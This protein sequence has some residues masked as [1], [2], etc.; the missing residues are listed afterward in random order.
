MIYCS[1][2]FTC[3]TLAALDKHFA[4]FANTDK[5]T[6]HVRDT[7]P[8]FELPICSNSRHSSLRHERSS[9]KDHDLLPEYDSTRSRRSLSETLSRDMMSR[10]CPEGFLGGGGL[11]SPSSVGS[12]SGSLTSTLSTQWPQSPVSSFA[13][14]SPKTVTSTDSTPQ[15][16]ERSVLSFA[17]T[18]SLATA[19][20]SPSAPLGDRGSRVRLLIVRH[21]QSANKQRQPGQKASAD[22]ELTDLG[23]E[24]AHALSQRL[25]REFP[26][27][28]LARNP[29]VIVSS[30][31]RRCL[32]TIHPTVQKLKL[33]KENC[34]CHGSCYE[35][36]CTGNERRTSTPEDIV[37]DFPEFSPIGFSPTGQWDYRGTNAK[38]TEQECKERCMRLAEWLQFEAAASLRARCV[39]TDAVKDMPTMVL[40]IHQSVAD[41]LCQIIV[42]GAAE[43]WSYGDIKHKLTNAAFTE[44]F[45]Y[46]NGTATFGVQ[47]EDYHSKRI[48][49]SLKP[50]KTCAW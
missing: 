29:P 10:T 20:A 48:R 46:A 11:L 44:V 18:C 49:F 43:N 25:A 19:T 30:P 31:M 40:A 17:G 14:M 22:P 41:L 3:G 36:G 2:G 32:L 38:E 13:A 15:K 33:S 8:R 34:L 42:E 47:N 45:L 28:V 6:D 16:K 39:G 4:K 35:F 5:A 9:T 23:Y 27:E 26:A 24:Q 37:Y 21:A 12:F 1:C 7:K 50:Q